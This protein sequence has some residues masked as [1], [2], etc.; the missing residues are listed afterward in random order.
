MNIVP[1]TRVPKRRKMTLY[2]WILF[3]IGMLFLVFSLTGLGKLIAPGALSL[4]VLSLPNWV[5]W[6]AFG[7]SVL[8]LAISSPYSISEDIDKYIVR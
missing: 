1:S 3:T 8:F 6:S 7:I 2:K 5:F 4:P